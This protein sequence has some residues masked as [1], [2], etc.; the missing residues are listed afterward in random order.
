MRL[1]T[2][3]YLLTKNTYFGS[4]PVSWDAIFYEMKEAVT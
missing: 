3:D 2:A 4:S 1:I